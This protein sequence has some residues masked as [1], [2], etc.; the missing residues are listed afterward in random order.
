MPIT[1]CFSYSADGLNRGAAQPN[2]LG[3]RISGTEILRGQGRTIIRARPEGIPDFVSGVCISYPVFACF[4]YL[5]DK[6]S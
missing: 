6:F 1:L 5:P 3:L 4:R 2:L